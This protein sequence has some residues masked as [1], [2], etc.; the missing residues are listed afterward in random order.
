MIAAQNVVISLLV[1]Q[2]E[3]RAVLSA[4]FLGALVA[5]GW[6]LFNGSVVDMGTLAWAQMAAGFLG[7]A[8]KA[9]QI[10]TIYQQGG[11]GQLSAFA[12]SSRKTIT[13]HKQSGV[14]KLVLTSLH[15]S[16]II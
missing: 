14:M 3:R 10:W 15:R 5:G 1:L 12:V 11:T 13:G 8:S 7:V 6:A 2:Y 4:G 16:S 9:P